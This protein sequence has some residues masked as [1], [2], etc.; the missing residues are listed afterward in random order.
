MSLPSNV[1][2]VDK[3]YGWTPLQAIIELRQKLGLSHGVSMTYAGRLDPLA[4]GALIILADEAVHL[5]E[6]YLHLEKTY[7]VELVFGLSTDSG[8]L[9]GLPVPV[10]A[11][12]ID[13]AGIQTAVESTVEWAYPQFSS[14]PVDGKALHDWGRQK[15][16]IAKPERPP[17]AMSFALSTFEN[18]EVNARE[19]I[20]QGFLATQIVHGDFRQ[21]EIQNAWHDIQLPETLPSLRL[22]AHVSSGTYIRAIPEILKV[23]LGLECVVTK[24]RR[25]EVG[26]YKVASALVLEEPAQ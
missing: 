20:R 16:E 15:A 3:P 13:I 25:T 18:A 14:K 19:I 2:L 10:E 17:R 4:S 9:L 21:D 24:I 11:M 1:Y 23:K 5:K 7:E 12:E 6:Q 22:T 8:D 26:D